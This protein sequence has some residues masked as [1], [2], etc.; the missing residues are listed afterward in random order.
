WN[1]V[2]PQPARRSPRAPEELRLGPLAPPPKARRRGRR[3]AARR[4]SNGS[5]EQRN[6]A[7]TTPGLLKRR[8]RPAARTLRAWGAL[9]IRFFSVAWVPS[10][11]DGFL[12]RRRRARPLRPRFLARRRPGARGAAVAGQPRRDRFRGKYA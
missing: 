11:S 6:G 2:S 10:L 12:A 1:A 4:P 5:N 7:W 8:S 9:R 3:G